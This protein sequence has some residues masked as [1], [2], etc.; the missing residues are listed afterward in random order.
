MATVALFDPCTAS[1][2]L[3]MAPAVAAK[4]DPT[5]RWLLDTGCPY[6][7]TSRKNLFPCELSMLRPSEV[8]VELETANGVLKVDVSAHVQVGGV[9]ENI[10]PYVLEETPDVLSVGF[11]CTEKGTGSTGNRTRSTRRS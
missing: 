8:P 11:R 9:C 7:L 10:T 1:T 3:T 2:A 4:V 5:R 6:D